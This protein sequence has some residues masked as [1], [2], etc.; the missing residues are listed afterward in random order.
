MR[1]SL[2]SLLVGTLFGAG[3][4]VSGMVNPAKVIGFL[5]FAGD[6][7]PTLGVVMASALAISVPGF[8]LARRRRAPTLGGAFQVPSRKDIDMRLIGGA[9]LFGVGW[10]LAGFCP[11]PAIAALA[12][13]LWPVFVFVAAMLT[14][15]WLYRALAR[16]SKA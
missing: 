1:L 16:G 15:I 3:L 12:T 10:G 5:D 8:A 2:A 13:G 4:A 14:G 9:V 7:D 6:W 11:G